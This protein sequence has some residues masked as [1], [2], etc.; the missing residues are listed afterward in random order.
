MTERVSL[1]CAM[2]PP[3][4]RIEPPKVS[5]RVS[6]NRNTNSSTKFGPAGSRYF[7]INPA[8]ASPLSDSSR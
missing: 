1:H 5:P 2:N 4:F 3:M 6:R 8:I 7:S